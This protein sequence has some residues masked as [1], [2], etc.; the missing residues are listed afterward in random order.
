MDLFVQEKPQQLLFS[1]LEN[2]LFVGYGGFGHID[3]GSKNAEVS[4]VIETKFALDQKKWAYT[5]S[6]YI[7]ILKYIA[8]AE[9]GFVKLHTFGYETEPYIF[10]FKV[11]LDLNFVE[12]ARLKKHIMIE[13]KFHDVLIHSYFL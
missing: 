10:K 9:L 4:F 7:Q 11:L 2:G 8:K 5:F 12:E 1:F 6:I 13:N 3:W